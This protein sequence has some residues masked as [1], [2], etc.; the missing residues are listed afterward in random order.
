M[1]REEK[2]FQLFATA[3]LRNGV[4]VEMAAREA[5]EAM[6]AFE[7]AR[8][9]YMDPEALKSLIKDRVEFEVA[10]AVRLDRTA[11]RTLI[12]HLLQKGIRVGDGVVERTS[13][14]ERFGHLM[15]FSRDSAVNFAREVIP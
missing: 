9:D 10:E 3:M 4:T 15:R 7:K 12:E 14:V 2:R 5:N 6:E 13:M 8:P 11:T 1:D